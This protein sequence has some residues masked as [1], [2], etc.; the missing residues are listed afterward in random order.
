M[1][2]TDDDYA[3]LTTPDDLE[4]LQ[5]ASVEIRNRSELQ[6]EGEIK[7]IL[8][9]RYNVDLIFGP[10]NDYRDEFLDMI[11]MDITLYNLYAA[12]PGR[13]MSDIRRERYERALKFLEDI[14]DYKRDLDLPYAG[15]DGSGT[16]P[17]GGS[18]D[19]YNPIAW[20]SNKKLRS[21]W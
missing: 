11:V 9:P 19:I 2:L 14:Q 15:D 4:V 12:I 6:A 21:I 13:I 5:Q 1:Y 8:R 17:D 18:T 10:T 16:N 20:A 7:S 3:T